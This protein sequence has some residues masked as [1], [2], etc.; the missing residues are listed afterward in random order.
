MPALSKD[1]RIK[2]ELVSIPAGLVFTKSLVNNRG[3]YKELLQELIQN[4]SQ[5]IKI[6]KDDQSSYNQISKRAKHSGI[7]LLKAELNGILYIRA[8]TISEVRKALL[9]SMVISKTLNELRVLKLQC[10]LESELKDLK[11]VGLIKLSAA[12]KWC[13]T[14]EGK[15]EVEKT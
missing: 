14:E 11:D 8:L 10:N 13:L 3:F 5:C 1:K 2:P 6:A 15:R 9:A 4:P 7:K 12:S